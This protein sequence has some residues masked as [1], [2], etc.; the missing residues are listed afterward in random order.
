MV[1]KMCVAL[2]A[3]RGVE[4]LSLRRRGEYLDIE[5]EWNKLTESGQK[6]SFLRG[7]P[8]R[9]EVKWGVLAMDFESKW[10]SVERE[11][12]DAA[13]ERG[14]HTQILHICRDICLSND[15]SLGTFGERAGMLLR[16]SLDQ[17]L[18]K[19]LFSSVRGQ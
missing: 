5:M 13:I 11:L 12:L 4:A 16:N 7:A 6:L 8:T 17:G 9:E 14:N 1:K 3:K 2:A 15:S 19:T 10:T 18:V